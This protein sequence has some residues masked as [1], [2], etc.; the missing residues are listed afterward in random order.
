[1]HLGQDGFVSTT[2][3]RTEQFFR[4]HAP[5]HRPSAAMW[6]ALRHIPETI[7]QII[8]G[9]ANPHY[10]VSALDC[11]V[12]KTVTLTQAL[13][14]MRQGLLP[15]SENVGTVVCVG[16]YAQMDATI[17]DMGLEP[18]DYACFVSE[19]SDDVVERADGSTFTVGDLRAAGLGMEN[20]DRAPILFTTHSMVTRRLAEN[21]RRGM[22]QWAEARE[23]F[24]RGQP[25][26]LRIWDEDMLPG[27]P[28]VVAE[29]ALNRLMGFLRSRKL[30]PVHDAIRELFLTMLR[31]EPGDLL[32]VPPLDT[33]ASAQEVLGHLSATE[34]EMIQE[35]VEHLWMLAGGVARVRT[36][37]DRRVVLDFRGRLPEDMTPMIVLDA[38]ARIRETYMMQA[39]EQGNV[40]FLR[41]APKRFDH[42]KLHV[43]RVGSGKDQ[44]LKD[45]DKVAREVAEVVNRYGPRDCLVLTHKPESKASDLRALLQPYL[46]AG[47]EPAFLTWGQHDATNAYA[48]RRVVICAST[49]FFNDGTCEAIGRAA[50][51][52][53]A[54]EEFSNGAIA[55]I[56]AGAALANLQQGLSRGC[57]RRCEG[58]FAH[59]G[60]LYLRLSAKSALAIE[61]VHKLFVGSPTP[62]EDWSGK[63]A[64]VRPAKTSV[65]IETALEMLPGLVE[66]GDMITFA[67][68]R[69]AM[70]DRLGGVGSIHASNFNAHFRKETQRAVLE[71][72]GYRVIEGN[73]I[74]NVGPDGSGLPFTIEAA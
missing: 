74:W 10:Y 66:V 22:R 70:R 60:E 31:A 59:A 41:H 46:K 25:R 32:P 1:M 73:R 62:A 19:T 47:K 21:S 13:K 11:G 68:L 30:A 8:R 53:P 5:T 4:Q 28:V 40:T 26:Q 36:V 48:D 42:V 72:H 54:A 20:A 58:D 6:D 35:D 2:M 24:Y 64:E 23:F 18:A 27:L 51:S 33:L 49:Y 55:R 65:W 14:V 56:K 29:D 61:R 50:T 45:P 71:R 34:R 43:R 57:T 52:R 67:D 38:S 16:R 37:R 3:L 12:G 17:A 7:S 63:G 15:G 69:V 44:L 39:E 9:T